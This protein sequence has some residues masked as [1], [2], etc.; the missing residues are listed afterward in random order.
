LVDI[1]FF[2]SRV[3]FFF[4]HFFTP[5]QQYFYRFFFFVKASPRVLLHFVSK[6]GTPLVPPP[7]PIAPPFFFCSHGNNP[8]KSP[9][10]T[11]WVFPSPH[12]VSS[13]RSDGDPHHGLPPFGRGSFPKIRFCPPFFPRLS[14][15]GVLTSFR[16]T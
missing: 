7:A 11:A 13:V 12:Y 9:T 2:S 4:S 1:T 10:G 16:D 14:S 8:G 3:R 5:F 6:E 15:F